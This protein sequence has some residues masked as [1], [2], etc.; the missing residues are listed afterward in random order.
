VSRSQVIG[1]QSMVKDSGG[2]RGIALVS[3]VLFQTLLPGQNKDSSACPA[4]IG[5]PAGSAPLVAV[6]SRANQPG[7]IVCGNL[8]KRRNENSVTASEFDV[9]QRGSDKPILEFDA[10]RHA[11]IVAGESRISVT[12]IINWPFGPRWE[13]TDV[14]LREYVIDAGS[15]PAVKQ[16]IVLKP[17]KHT[18]SEIGG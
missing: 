15:P 12:E 8:E 11:E 17:P 18:P 2:F 6:R 13:W 16:R 10:L 9:F 4:N 14:P 3:F 7:L 5:A 1:L